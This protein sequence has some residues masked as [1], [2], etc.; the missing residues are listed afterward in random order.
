MG[1]GVVFN[2]DDAYV[3][4]V[5]SIIVPHTTSRRVLIGIQPLA[6][7]ARMCICW[8]EAGIYGRAFLT[9]CTCQILS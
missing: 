5:I 6:Y 9:I 1:Y 8:P 7:V 4:E 2:I 3:Q